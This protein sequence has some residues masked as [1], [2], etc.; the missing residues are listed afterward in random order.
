MSQK[1]SSGILLIDKPQGVTSH[2]IVAATR[3]ALH[4]KKVGHAGTLDPMAT[5]LLIVAFGN[6]TKL[7][8][9]IIAHDKT[10][11]ATFRFGANTTSD[12]A[13]GDF[14][15]LD[16]SSVEKL[17]YYVQHVEE[18]ERDLKESI[19][20]K[21]MGD[22]MQVPNTFSA[23]KVQGKRA[24]D[25]AREGKQ[26]D[27]QARKITIFEYDLLSVSLVREEQAQYI[28][29]DVLVHCSSG[30]YI[31]A[32][33]RDMGTLLNT[34]AYVTRLRRVSIGSMNVDDT[35]CLQAKRVEKEFT[36]ADGSKIIRSKAKLVNAHATTSQAL[37]MFECAKNIL[38]VLEV[39]EHEAADLRMGRFVQADVHEPTIAVITGTQEVVAIVNH[40]KPIARMR[41]SMPGSW[42]K[43]EVVFN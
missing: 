7:L 22:I 23:I 11:E 4:M 42:I 39:S 8:Q 10:Y 17:Q 16:K 35:R 36:N 2:D 33:A 19:S 28:D 40:Y 24:Y 27:L 34:G 41:E 43:P 38:P 15:A 13:E 20:Q 29:C 18:F 1:Q 14:L 32:L 6:A 3:S 9:Y 30:T 25:L 31:R 12:D 5:G 37:S 21:F 26:V